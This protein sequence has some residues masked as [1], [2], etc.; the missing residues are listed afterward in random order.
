MADCVKVLDFGLVREY[1]YDAPEAVNADGE[2][3]VEGTPWFMPPEAIQ[4][5][6]PTDPRSDLYSLG[7][8]GYFLLTG[9]YIFDADSIAEIHE[10]QLTGTPIPPSQRTTNPISQEME[11]LLLR[12]LEK[13]MDLRP[14]S[15]GELQSLLI[16]T[17][18]AGDWP[19]EARA[20]WWDA[21][22]QQPAASE[23]ETGVDASTPMNTVSIDLAS[24]MD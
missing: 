19:R 11:Q 10:K 2:R 1:R 7:A 16:A 21:Y 8:L 18:C 9:N 23:V 5:S 22:E 17:P 14:Q 3:T 4:D 12:C 13:D 6:A 24:R 15:A 20:S